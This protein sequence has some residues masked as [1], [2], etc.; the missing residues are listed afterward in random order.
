MK[1]KFIRVFLQSGSKYNPMGD[2]EIAIYCQCDEE[3]PSI[4]DV[5][6]PDLEN[7]VNSNSECKKNQS[8][9]RY[10]VSKNPGTMEIIVLEDREIRC[11]Q[12]ANRIF[13]R[14]AMEGIGK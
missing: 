13:P 4:E 3:N 1:K 8:K 7:W 12:T 10:K 9:E 6:V 11:C 5:N 14:L 2:E